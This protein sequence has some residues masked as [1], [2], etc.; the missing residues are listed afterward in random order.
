M[1]LALS[2]GVSGMSYDLLSRGRPY[3]GCPILN[4]KSLSLCVTPLD[5]SNRFCCVRVCDSSGVSYLLI[6]VYM[7]T[8]YGPQS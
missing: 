3:G 1:R 5:S 7:P 4:Q 2:V 8:D 6:C